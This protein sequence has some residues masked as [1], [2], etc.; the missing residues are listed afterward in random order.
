MA[1]RASDSHPPG[2]LHDN[3]GSMPGFARYQ[4]CQ[5]PSRENWPNSS[6]VLVRAGDLATH[7]RARAYENSYFSGLTH[8][9]LTSLQR[10]AK[11]IAAKACLAVGSSC[12]NLRK[13][14]QALRV[15]GAPE[16]TGQPTEPLLYPHALRPARLP[17]KPWPNWLPQPW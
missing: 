12:Q 14:S 17:S 11:P 7:S 2:Q 3:R 9:A 1:A 5:P 13:R 15:P 6:P 10:V 4:G 16:K 8:R